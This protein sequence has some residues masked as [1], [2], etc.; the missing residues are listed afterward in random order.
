[1]IVFLTY[2]I[3][4]SIFY[5]NPQKL[6]YWVYK[7]FIGDGIYNDEEK[8]LEYIRSLNLRGSVDYFDLISIAGDELIGAEN[9]GLESIGQDF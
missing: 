6:R 3:I 9:I 1:M 2:P 4:N 7:I 8:A 5:Y